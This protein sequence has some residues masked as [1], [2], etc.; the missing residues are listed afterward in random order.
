DELVVDQVGGHPD[1]GQVTA[2]LPDH[3][4]PGGERD[5]VREPLHRHGV[6]IMDRALDGLGE[7]DDLRHQRRVFPGMSVVATTVVICPGIGFT[8]LLSRKLSCGITA[9]MPGTCGTW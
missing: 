9:R 1:Q 2:P 8:P 3:L 4:V 7:R 5:E 6:T